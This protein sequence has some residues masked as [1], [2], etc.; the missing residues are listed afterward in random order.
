MSS[1][2]P[3]RWK[4]GV[5]AGLAV[6]IV[7]AIPQGMMWIDRGQE[8]HGAFASVDRDELAYS[9][10]LASIVA[11][12]PRRNNPYLGNR[13][14]AIPTE[15]LFSVQFFPPYVLAIGAK[16]I[17]TSASNAFI[18]AYPICAFTASI[19]IFWLLSLLTDDHKTA[20]IGVLIVLLCGL[21]LSESP[22]ATQ[23]LFYTFAFLRRYIPAVPFPFFFLFTGCIWRAFTTRSRSSILWSAAAAGAFALLVYSYFYLWTAALAWFACLVTV[24]MI[25]RP[26][27]RRHL[28]SCLSVTIPLAF[29]ALIPYL[30]ILSHRSNTTDTTQGLLATHIPDLFRF[31][32]I[33]GAVILAGLT[34]G[35]R[36]GL[37]Q[38]SS[39]AV[40]FTA[41]CAITPFAV[42]NQQIVTG[43]SLQPFHYDQF[44]INY[45]VLVGAVLVLHFLLN[46][47]RRFTVYWIAIA[48]AIGIATG[49]KSYSLEAQ[50]NRLR[51]ES[52]LLYREIDRYS[53]EQNRG[54]ALFDTEILAKDAPTSSEVGLLWSPFMYTFGSTTSSEER[55]RF[56]Q[57]LYFLGVDRAHF[58]S[59][60]MKQPL[61]LATLFGHVRVYK[62]LSLRF[63]PVS[64]E[65]IHSEAESYD[66]YFKNF[67]LG[68]ASRWPL[69]FVI[70]SDRKN[71]DMSNLDRWYE[72][73]GEEHVGGSTLFRIHLKQSNTLTPKHLGQP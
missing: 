25:V 41:S 11:G 70:L 17:G 24:W 58:E 12:R 64:E 43:Y 29:G 18:I 55:E 2:R 72:R 23:K 53:Q 56:Y 4:F 27:D 47:V 3:I 10:Y 14:E 40:L 26:T 71:I 48:L 67:S 57:F 51:D 30:Y 31:T 44:V 62:V 33:I 39:P 8:W 42:F 49:L 20:A 54:L 36:R 9:A 73:D 68:Q 38:W 1:H 59:E 45:L 66:I 35:V 34:F 15:N 28:V 69:S 32:E 52:R 13:S 63:N 19:A 21:M 5:L 65:E 16:A 7:T 50:S 22:F 46:G 6:V 37:I 61:Y 60:I